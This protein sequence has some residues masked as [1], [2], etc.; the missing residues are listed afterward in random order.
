MALKKFTNTPQYIYENF[1]AMLLGVIP[2]ILIAGVVA[3][4]WPTMKLPAFF[5]V[6]VWWLV[7]GVS[8]MLGERRDPERSNTISIDKLALVNAL[9]A[10]ATELKP[11]PIGI[12]GQMARSGDN[13]GTL[14]ELTSKKT[15][16][17]ALAWQKTLETMADL[18]ELQ[19]SPITEEQ[20]SYIRQTLFQ[21]AGGSMELNWKDLAASRDELKN[22][23]RHPPGDGR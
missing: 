1:G 7:G 15:N 20:I 18:L 8:L 21:S 11:S 13:E 2:A 23:L 5:I 3:L 22:L 10:T 19:E 16:L 9:R 14:Q 17:D 4:V 12:S 6:L